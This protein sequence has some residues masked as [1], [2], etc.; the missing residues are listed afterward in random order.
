LEKVAQVFN[1]RIPSCRLD[2]NLK[3]KPADGNFIGEGQIFLSNLAAHKQKVDVNLKFSNDGAKIDAHSKNNGN[4]MEVSAFLPVSLKSNGL[5]T[6]NLH[7]NTLDCHI[8]ANTQ[9][10]KLLELSDN[11]DLRGNLNCDLHITG[12]FTNPIIS[13]KAQLNRAYIG[14]DDV[15]LRNGT[16]SLIGNGKNIDVVLAE[17][18]DYKRKK[19]TISGGGKLF[20][21]GVV[22]NIETDLKLKFNNFTLFDSDNLKIDV[23]G[24][25]YMKGPLNDMIIGGDVVVPKCEIQDFD[26]EEKEPDIV[27]ENDCHLAGHPKNQERSDFFKYNVS[28]HCKDIKFVGN[29]FETHLYGDLLLSTYQE[30]GTLIGELKLSGGKLDL[31]GKRMKFSKGKVTFLKEFPFD[32]K[33]S[34]TC[35]RNFGDI[36]VLLDIE[37]KP[38]KGVSLNLHS[39]PS[40]TR[41]VILSKMLFGKESKYLTMGEAA[42]L[43][44]AV[45]GLKQRGYIFSVLNTF[46]NIGV[47]DNI[48]FGGSDSQSNSLYS[49]SQNTS[50]QNNISISA[51]K[52]IHDNVYISV[53]KKSEGASF[54]IDFSITPKIS[55]KANTRGEAGVSWKFRY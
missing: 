7:A 6:R 22:P 30:K 2:G 36:N 14:I 41:D 5:I 35:K 15:L 37:N 18:V 21:D 54:D 49:N 32:P 24:D 51:G 28:M 52:Y 50:L 26:T 43:A 44:H 19:A 38:G 27:I 20:F 47:I 1:R 8:R 9:L 25:G 11:S 23:I 46:Q 53:N 45:T 33:A 40:Y 4:S 42:Q 12:N 55:I 17:F 39:T 34:F 29:I 3:L 31:F 10:E 16:I 13:G 48:S